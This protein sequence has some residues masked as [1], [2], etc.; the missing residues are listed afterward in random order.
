MPQFNLTPLLV[1][2]AAGLG[3]GVV[4]QVF[5]SPGTPL[6]IYRASLLVGGG[7]LDWWGFNP[8]IGT[9]M[10]IWG[11]GALASR[12]PSFLAGKAASSGSA[13]KVVRPAM[14]VPPRHHVPGGR[15]PGELHVLHGGRTARAFQVHGISTPGPWHGPAGPGIF[16]GPQQNYPV[17]SIA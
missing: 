5:S 13:Y 7:A 15:A 17:G 10:M 16:P 3:D 11:S 4:G 6:T 12:I 8:N 2:T 9:A 14:A 1:G